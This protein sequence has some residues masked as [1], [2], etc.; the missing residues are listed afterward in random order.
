MKKRYMRFISIVFMM[1]CYFNK[2]ISVS[3][4]GDDTDATENCIMGKCSKEQKEALILAIILIST[5]V[6]IFI[7][8]YIWLSSKEK[9]KINKILSKSNI[10]K[11]TFLNQAFQ[12]FCDVQ[13]SWMDFDYNRLKVLLSDE[14]Y[15]T[16]TALLESLKSK[17][18]KNIVGDFELIG[19]RLIDMNED[20][21][22]YIAKVQLEVKSIDYIENIETNEMVKGKD[23]RKTKCVYMLT[24]IKRREDIEKNICQKCGNPVNNNTGICDYCKSRFVNETY[25]WVLSNKQIIMK[26]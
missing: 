3:A 19:I 20:K 15:N 24:F 5:A 10:D 12:M 26:R 9:R 17:K 8:K 1:F 23:K 18:Q 22:V 14:L 2:T 4:I 6:L 25:D 21:N 16:Y 11:K 13:V 7:I